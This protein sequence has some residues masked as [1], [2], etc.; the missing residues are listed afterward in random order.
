MKDKMIN[1]LI[2]LLIKLDENR[3][4]DIAV[5]AAATLDICPSSL[6]P[7]DEAWCNRGENCWLCWQKYLKRDKIS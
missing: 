1:N 6:L 5:Y 2:D 7:S 3:L 4:V